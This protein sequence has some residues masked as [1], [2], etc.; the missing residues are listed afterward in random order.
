[1]RT[2]RRPRSPTELR[3][4]RFRPSSAQSCGGGTEQVE[5]PIEAQIEA[6]VEPQVEAWAEPQ[7]ET[8]IEE[9]VEVIQT[10]H[11]GENPM[12][13]A[14]DLPP[15][16][17]SGIVSA[18][19][20]SALTANDTADEYDISGYDLSRYESLAF[21]EPDEPEEER[22]P[23]RLVG[24]DDPDAAEDE[25]EEVDD[26]AVGAGTGNRRRSRRSGTRRRTRP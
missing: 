8:P 16:L 9:P 24:S 12:A 4:L 5:N 3:R 15:V 22:E 14:A 20:K 7:V 11:D 10:R 26:E 1:V 13:I 6:R 21:E 17:G 23:L 2:Q 18:A 25:D 19:A